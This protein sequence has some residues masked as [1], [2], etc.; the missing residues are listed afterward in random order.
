MK[1]AISQVNNS[2][3][4]KAIQNQL[5]FLSWFVYDRRDYRLIAVFKTKGI[6]YKGY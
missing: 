1:K 5:G 3:I 6:F 2:N 4:T